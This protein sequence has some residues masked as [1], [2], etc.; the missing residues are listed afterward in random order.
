MSGVDVLAGIP[1][2][3]ERGC[4]LSPSECELLVELAERAKAVSDSIS[5]RI[6]DPRCELHCKLADALAAAGRR[7]TTPDRD[8]I[9][10]MSVGIPP[11]APDPIADLETSEGL[12]GLQSDNCDIDV[13]ESVYFRPTR[14][15][16]AEQVNLRG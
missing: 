14:D 15:E 3:R 13:S 4:V 6:D 10:A 16:E 8:F 7:P 1:G 11:M 2:I 12:L 5:F 9:A